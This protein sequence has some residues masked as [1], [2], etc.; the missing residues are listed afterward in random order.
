MNHR[1]SKKILERVGSSVPEINVWKS[2][3]ADYVMNKKKH[4]NN[5]YNNKQKLPEP[6]GVPIDIQMKNHRIVLF[7]RPEYRK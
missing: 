4:C 5:F 7:H 1:R 3:I 6:P 2:G